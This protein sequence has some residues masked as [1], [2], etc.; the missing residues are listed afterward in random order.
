MKLVKLSLLERIY[1]VF[2]PRKDGICDCESA[3][4]AHTMEI[5][6]V[7]NALGYAKKE[8]VSAKNIIDDYKEDIERLSERLNLTVSNY[9]ELNT[10]IDM[11]RKKNSELNIKVSSSEVRTNKQANEIKYLNDEINKLSNE[12]PNISDKL[13]KKPVHKTGKKSLSCKDVKTAK[14][15]HASGAKIKDLAKKLDVSPSTLS[16]A[17]NGITYKKCI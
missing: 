3:S 8:L 10:T 17:I 15:K 7:R 13:N 11:L 1:R 2:V 6:S 16:R 9:D 4:V 14:K 5:E 12:L